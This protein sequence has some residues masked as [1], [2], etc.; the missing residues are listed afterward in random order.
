MNYLKAK[1]DFNFMINFHKSVIKLWEIEKE[2]AKDLDIGHGNKI[3]Y[4]AN[5]QAEASKIQG[6]QAIRAQ[7]AKG[8]LL[9]H[10][11]AGSHGVP[12]IFY[13]YPAPAVGGPVIDQPI[14]SAIL[15]DLSHGGQITNQTIYDTINQTIG[16]CKAAVSCEKRRLLN[17]INW[18]WEII[19]FIVRIPFLLI[20]ASGFDVS[21]VEDHLLSKLFK[22]AEIAFILYVLWRLG[23][24]QENLKQI[25]MNFF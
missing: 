23:F 10:R 16:E 25:L 3:E 19:S 1:S 4:Q 22:L 5:L 8:I 9:A 13:S 15:K 12:N 20:Q 2:A 24:E 6:Y 18:I 14:Y 7:V 11:I 21:K 17:P